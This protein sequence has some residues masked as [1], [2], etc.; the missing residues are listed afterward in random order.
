MPCALR[1]IG[2]RPLKVASVMLGNDR[3]CNASLQSQNSA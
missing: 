2:D 1:S 3:K